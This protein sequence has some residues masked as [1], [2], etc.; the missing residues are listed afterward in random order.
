MADAI[1]LAD[2]VAG[3]NRAIEGATTAIA[4]EV[5]AELRQAT[6]VDTRFA[7]SS[8]IPSVGAPSAEMG[9]SPEAPSPSAAEAGLA[10]VA[11]FR[12]SDGKAHVANNARYIKFLD[13]GSSTQQPAGFVRRC[14]EQ[15]LQAAARV[16]AASPTLSGLRARYVGGR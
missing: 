5:T 15:G 8:W 6:P 11:A 12:L 3:L 4:I 1:N 10:R 9:G 14:I 7:A 2:V 16:I 13:E